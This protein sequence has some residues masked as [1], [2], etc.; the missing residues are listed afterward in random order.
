MC[1]SE[2][3]SVEEE[4]QSWKD[5]GNNNSGGGKVYKVDKIVEE[6]S[7]GPLVMCVFYAYGYVKADNAVEP[8]NHMPQKFMD[9]Y[10]RRFRETGEEGLFSIP[11][12]G[13]TSQPNA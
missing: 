12:R 1:G 8:P 11:L 7:S 2:E 13:P 3:K 4:P 10:Y 9:M 6:T 5:T